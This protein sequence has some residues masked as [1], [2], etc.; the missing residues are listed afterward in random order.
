[1]TNML[2]G[3]YVPG[4]SMLHKLAAGIKVICLCMLAIAVVVTSTIHGYA[5]M[6]IG[7]GVI[8]GLSRLSPSAVIAPIARMRFFFVIIF[9]MNSL[10]YSSDQPLLAWGIISIT[11]TGIKQGATVVFNVVYIMALA[12]VLT[13]TTTPIDL[14]T[15]LACLLKPLRFFRVPVEDV[16]MIIGIA[17]RFIPTL[18]EEAEMIKKAQTARGAKF[19]SKKFRER[20]SSFLQLLIPVFLAAFRR[21]DELSVAMEARGYRNARNRTPKA[22]SPLK[23]QDLVAL[24]GC[25]S[26]CLAQIYF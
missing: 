18:L 9:L 23:S 22:T 25:I 6:L 15:G 14:T 3:Q 16:A 5:A 19:E 10:F 21:A 26:I 8:V 7:L 11:Q 17:V 24:G 2:A 13:C 12:N 1:M 20:A 4:N